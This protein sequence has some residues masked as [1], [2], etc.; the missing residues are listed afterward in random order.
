MITYFQS[1]FSDLIEWPLS[2][3]QQELC[4]TITRLT[5]ERG[6]PPSLR[7]IAAVMGVNPSRISALAR[8]AESRGALTPS[9]RIP[10]SW[11]VVS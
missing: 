4:G 7:E 8:V 6:F 3:R 11:R 10:R 2:G 9:P 1:T 5:A